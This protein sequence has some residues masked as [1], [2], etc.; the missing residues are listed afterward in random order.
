[1]IEREFLRQ[2]VERVMVRIAVFALAGG[3]AGFVAG[4]TGA[5]IV[6]A[7]MR[8]SRMEGGVGALAVG[9]GILSGVLGMVATLLAL[10][11]ARGVSGAALL[12]GTLGSLAALAI[13]AAAGHWRYEHSQERFTRKYGSVKLQFELARSTGG[14]ATGEWPA[15][16]IR[17]DGDS[18]EVSWE[19][20]GHGRAGSA[21]LYRLTSRRELILRTPGEPPRN[22]PLSFPRDPSRASAD[23]SPWT[24][25]ARAEASSIRYRIIR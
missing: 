21:R 17:E 10:L 25:T 18:R 4:A 19:A 1:L 12:A 7:A 2:K 16:E 9:V 15:V 20:G 22:L 8:M 14:S 3:L 6:A 23:W 24:G 5:S 11:H 13:F